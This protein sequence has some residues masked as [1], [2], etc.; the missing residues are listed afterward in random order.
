MTALLFPED[1]S[2]EELIAN[3]NRYRVELYGCMEQRG[4]DVGL[5]EQGEDGRLSFPQVLAM[6]AQFTT[7]ERSAWDQDV[8][9]CQT[10]LYGRPGVPDFRGQ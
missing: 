7:E 5:P 3:N 1:E 9:S 4:W 6:G 10:E 2:D 8:A